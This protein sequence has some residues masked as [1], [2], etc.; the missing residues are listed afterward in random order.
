[1]TKSYKYITLVF[2]DSEG[3][4]AAAYTIHEVDAR[5]L[6]DALATAL[7]APSDSFEIKVQGSL[8]EGV[9]RG[10]PPKREDLAEFSNRSTQGDS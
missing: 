3:T 7:A 6:R 5:R 1:V 10:G 2:Y 9:Y 4:Q 8:A